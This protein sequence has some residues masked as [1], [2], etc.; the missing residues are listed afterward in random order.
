MFNKDNQT[1]LKNSQNFLHSEKLVSELIAESNIC[2]D[3]IVIE[4]GGGKGIITKQLV[5]RCKKLYV[6]EYDFQLYKALKDK[7]SNVKNIELIY[8]DFLEFKLQMES[9][10][11]V[12]SS[13]PY[14]ITAAILSKLTSSCN[15]PEDMYIILQKEAA[16]KYAGKPFNRESMRSLL[17]KPYFDFDI[18]RNLKR[19]DF[20]PVPGVDS[21][22]LHVKKRKNILVRQDKENLYSDFIAYIFDNTGKDMKTRCKNI[23]SYKQI[24]RL[25]RD[26]GFGMTDSPTCLS[27]EQWLKVFQYFAI[28]VSDEK[29]N[30][31]NNAYSKLLEKQK[32][33]DKIHRSNR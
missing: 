24:K 14:N 8:G 30:V 29:K 28:G 25:S 20:N 4:I 26:I 27:Y 7:L 12:F 13:I 31:V 16:L 10:Y 5:K 23:F 21:V 17:L 15:P 6:I 9:K 1:K 33:I 11:K 22:L 3:D 19:N 2:E 18:V 32:K